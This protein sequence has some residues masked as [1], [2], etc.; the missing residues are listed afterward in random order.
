MLAPAEC[1]SIA[2]S[3]PMDRVQTIEDTR[4][5]RLLLLLR[6]FD[7]IQAFADRIE[8][9][10]AQVSQWKNRSKRANGR[11]STIDSDSARWIEG[12]T[13]KPRGWMDQPTAEAVTTLA[14]LRP[15][16]AG[17]PPLLA[18]EP[19]A[20]YPSLSIAVEQLG[21][22]MSHT[23][24]DDVREDL[25]DALAKLARRKGAPHDREMVLTLLKRAA[26]SGGE[27]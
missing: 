10:H 19:R 6:E 25:A 16:G 26:R 3:Y 4:H 22:A 23:M 27:A 24:P 11:V 12:K 18:E 15:T 21:S 2:I 13:G 9:A 17:A 7:T 1:Q 8:R 5:A 14:L 20:T